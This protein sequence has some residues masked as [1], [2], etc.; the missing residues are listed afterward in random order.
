[1]RFARVK[2]FTQVIQVDTMTVS[3]RRWKSAFALA[4]ISALDFSRPSGQNWRK[5]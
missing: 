5:T 4:T 1:M 2:L 3:L